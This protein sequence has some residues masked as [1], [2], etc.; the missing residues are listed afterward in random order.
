MHD[1][2]PLRIALIIGSTRADRFADLPARWIADGISAS[3]GVT[4]DTLDL[5]DY[6]LP[7]LGDAGSD[8]APAQSA[9][10]AWRRDVA[11]ADAYIVTAAEYNHAPTAVLKN[12]LDHANTEWHRKPVAFVGYG[13]LGGARA[14][15]HLRHIAIELQMAPIKTAIHIAADVFADVREGRARLDAF[16]HLERGRATMIDQLVFWARALRVARLAHGLAFSSAG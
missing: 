10:T 4:L 14:I 5:R 6:P 12:A 1:I 13:G 2:E 7:F 9:I 3:E 8:S 16:P 15:E 11:R